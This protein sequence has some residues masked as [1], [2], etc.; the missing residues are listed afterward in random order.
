MT[1]SPAARAPATHHSASDDPVPSTPTPR[2]PQQHEPSPRRGRRRI[3]ALAAF[4]ALT[5][6]VVLASLALGPVTISPGDTLTILFDAV[7]GAP[8]D[9]PGALVVTELRLPRALLA[10]LA[11]CGL[12]VAGASMQ[13][14]FRNP[15]AEPGVTGVASG[16][17]VG[18]VA[19]LVLGLDALGSW[20][21]PLAAFGGA[22]LVLLI[23]Q[24]VALASRDRGVA[25]VL[26]VGVALN[27]FCGALTGA[28]IANADDAQTVRGAMFWLQGDLTSAS[29]QDLTLSA[30]PV[31]LGV[32]AVLAMTRE[33]NA[34]LLGDEIAQT[35][36]VGV[37]R[38][39][40]QLLV[41]TSL[42]IGSIVAV[43]GVIGFVGLVAPH[44]VRLLLGSD[45]RFLLPA[46]ALLGGAFLVAADT[47][48]RL[49]PAGT[50]WQTGIVTALVGSP[51]FLVLV[52]RAR[53]TTWRSS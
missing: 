9:L 32:A 41:V 33:I 28:I 51:L 13:A 45:H 6:L 44:I 17:A 34:L 35:I 24:A 37:T 11:G 3:V 26:L 7:R 21:L 53:R 40:V 8:S 52:L 20:T 16:A 46:S 23:I 39:R 38:V 18:A 47:V 49:A 29:W 25:T 31:L 5:A 27:A 10:L 30:A 12:A 2:D 36:G 14:Y 48:A 19:V 4:A 1:F 50:S 22:L 15:L 43:T 42:V